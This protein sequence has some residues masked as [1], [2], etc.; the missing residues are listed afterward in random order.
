M[1]DSSQIEVLATARNLAFLKIGRNIFNF[2]LVEQWLKYL[3]TMSDVNFVG[4]GLDKKTNKKIEKSQKMMLGQL[5]SDIL[6]TWH[7]DNQ[8]TNH[9]TEELFDI[10]LS[11]S[12]RM[13]MNLDDY[14]SLKQS[15]EELVKDRNY[16][17]HQFGKE[18]PLNNVESCHAAAIYLDDNREKHLSIMECIK[19]MTSSCQEAIKIQGEF[20]NS[21]ELWNHIEF[22]QQKT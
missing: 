20:L 9:R 3:V 17:V 11:V 2:S 12:F 5:I 14:N 16:L 8:S 22:E 15:L 21:D 10:R 4:L 1:A 18:F 7:P 13:E 19:G 6:D